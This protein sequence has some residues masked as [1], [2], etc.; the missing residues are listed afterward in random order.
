MIPSRRRISLHPKTCK[1]LDL[2]AYRG[3][4]PHGGPGARAI[5]RGVLTLAHEAE[6]IVS[7]RSEAVTECYAL[8]KMRLVARALG[9]SR[10]YAERLTRI[11]WTRLYPDNTD[12]YRTKRCRDGSRLDLNPL[13]SGFP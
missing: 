13:S 3:A 6:H 9:T 8:Q 1:G 10:A 2:F 12:E 11:A 5:A 4:R 7:G